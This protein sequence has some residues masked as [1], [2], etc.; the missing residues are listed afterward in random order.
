MII[1]F[2]LALLAVTAEG[3]DSGW[4]SGDGIIYWLGVVQDVSLAGSSNYNN[5][6]HLIVSKLPGFP[7]KR[8][9]VQFEDLPL[10]CS[11]SQILQ[12]CTCTMCTHIKRAGILSPILLSSHAI[13]RC[14]WS[15]KGG[16]KLKQQH[17]TVSVVFHGHLHG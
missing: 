15:K 16:V 5:L 3:V 1:V 14:T 2:M 11:S 9:L 6:E 4:D 7:N 17:T 13:W 8:S 10:R 12:R